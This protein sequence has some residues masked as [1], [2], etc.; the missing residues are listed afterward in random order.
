MLALS[1]RCQQTVDLVISF[2]MAHLCV[3]NWIQGAYFTLLSEMKSQYHLSLINIRLKHMINFILIEKDHSETKQCSPF[4]GPLEAEPQACSLCG[5][6][7]SARTQTSKSSHFFSLMRSEFKENG[8]GQTCFP[9]RPKVQEQLNL[10]QQIVPM[11]EILCVYCWFIHYLI[12]RMSLDHL[13]HAK[14]P[15]RSLRRTRKRHDPCPQ[16]TN[17]PSW[18]IITVSPN[19]VQHTWNRSPSQASTHCLGGG[20]GKKDV[21]SVGLSEL[22]VLLQKVL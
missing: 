12:P 18:E 11:D 22:D 3:N 10:P 2:M 20:T 19:V 5:K 7:R 14:H 21:P 8:I 9:Q 1:T 15:D 16:G 4:S 17:N 13:I 6:D